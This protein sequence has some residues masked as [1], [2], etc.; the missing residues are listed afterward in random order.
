MGIRIKSLKELG[1]GNWKVS[2]VIGGKPRIQFGRRRGKGRNPQ[3]ELFQMVKALYPDA[4]ENYVGS[5]PGRKFEL[6]VAFLDI[7]L[8]L[9]C[10]GWEFHGKH[11]SSFLRD[12]EKDRLL[13]LNGWRVLRFPVREILKSPD[14]VM[15]TVKKAVDLFSEK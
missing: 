2:E 7:R 3:D 12:R 8:G 14:E 1:K 6:D 4:I 15:A 5:I 9:E 11:L 10:D 13:L